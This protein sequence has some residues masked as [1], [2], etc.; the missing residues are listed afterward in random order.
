[1]NL[2]TWQNL[3][4]SAEAH[5]ARLIAVSKTYPAE[6]ILALYKSGQRL[7]G[8]NKVQEMAAK[9][10]VLP[11]DIAWHQVG[12]LQTNKVK[13]IAPFVSLIH[14]V[15]SYKLLEE[16]HGQAKKNNR[17]I[18]CLLQI[19][20]A[21]EDTKHGMDSTALHSLLCHP[22]LYCLTHIRICGL[23]GMATYTDDRAIIAAEFAGLQKLFTDT[24]LQYFADK[25]YF[26]ELSMGMSGDYDIALQ[27]GATL[28]RVGSAI[29]GTRA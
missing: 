8:E 20:I 19:H 4:T 3:Y 9:Y 27:H 13:Y 14:A 11:K 5:H 29:F 2:Q 6:S 22:D 12:H 16:I 15:D 18:D 7:F 28:I 23:M 26:A 24:R 10:E 1:M 25:A 21:S 17:V